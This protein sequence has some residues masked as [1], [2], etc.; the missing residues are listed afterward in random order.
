MWSPAV[1]KVRSMGIPCIYQPLKEGARAWGAGMAFPRTL[2]GRKLDA[3]YEFVNW[4]TSG[5]AGAFLFRQGYYS[6]VMDTAKQH[7]ESYE[8]DYWMLGKAATQDI[9]GPDGSV[10]E[11][12]GKIRDGGSFDARMGAVA[13]WNAVMDENRYMVKKWNEFVAA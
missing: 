1:T 7:M 5:W 11:K 2:K 12:A 13:C 4:Y 9:K 10:M 3:A 8:W 6:G